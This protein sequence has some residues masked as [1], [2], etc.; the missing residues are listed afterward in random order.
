MQI[1]GNLLLANYTRSAIYPLSAT[2]CRRQVV[3]SD[4]ILIPSTS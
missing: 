4:E 2:G 1:I 3:S